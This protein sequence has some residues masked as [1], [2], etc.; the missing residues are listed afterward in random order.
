MATITTT[1]TYTKLRNG[2]WGLRLT[3]DANPG[4][5][6]TVTRRDGSTKT[7]IVGRIL[8]SDG[9]VALATIDARTGRPAG[10]RASAAGRCGCACHGRGGA[11]QSCRFDGCEV[12]EAMG[13]SYDC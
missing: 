7:E 5:T 11:C 2:S 8:W 13:L 12:V 9:R 1:A 10:Y 3:H 4:A 6:V